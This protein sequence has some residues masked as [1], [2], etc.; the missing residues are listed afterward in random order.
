M[1]RQSNEFALAWASLSSGAIETGWRT[2]AVTAA[3]QCA[4][5][6]GRRF[7]ENQEAVLVG[8]AS[9]NIPAAEKLPEGQGF[10]V[11]HVSLPNESRTWVALTRKDG[12]SIELFMAMVC[13]I[14]GLLDIESGAEDTRLLRV[15][16]GRVRAWQEFMRKATG[17]LGPESEMGLVGE[18]LLL[19]RFLELGMTP[20]VA[21]AA[22]IGPLDGI[23]DFEIGAGA[24]EVKTTLASVGFPAH[25]GSLE[26]LDDSIRQ[27]L[28][29]AGMR[30]QLMPT[31][32][33]LPEI[34]EDTRDILFFNP[35]AART[36]DER[37]LRA[38]YFDGHRDQYRRRFGLASA[39]I[40]EVKGEFPRLTTGCVPNGITKATY[41][42]DLDRVSNAHIELQST[43]K[44]LGA[45]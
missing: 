28:F 45:L 11:E 33:T 22:W 32:K 25:I 36:F 23:Q 38:Q 20:E 1:A 16:L 9:I 40:I 35:D 39:S 24:I 2:I 13:D 30:L 10:T 21:T 19:G 44:Q 37:L 41:E 15:F 3:G 26:Q 29:V 14:T 17:A 6:A 31:G 34:V 12:G 18:L 42:I 5:S 27:P 8:F 4:L 43:L 7:P